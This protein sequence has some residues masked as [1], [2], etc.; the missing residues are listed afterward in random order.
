MEHAE[1]QP[2]L[3][4]AKSIACK[5]FMFAVAARTPKEVMFAVAADN[6]F[7]I[8]EQFYILKCVTNHYIVQFFL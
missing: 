8:G 2:V 7:D 5:A 3:L 6:A 1:N 4:F